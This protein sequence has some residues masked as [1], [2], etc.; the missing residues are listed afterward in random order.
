MLNGYAEV[1]RV[2]TLVSQEQLGPTSM[3]ATALYE[4]EVIRHVP[5][6]DHMLSWSSSAPVATCQLSEQPGTFSRPAL[7]YEC[8]RGRCWWNYYY[9]HD[10]RRTW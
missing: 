9:R 6:Y 4:R 1:T 8:N 3:A 7:F 2:E 5:G 10:G